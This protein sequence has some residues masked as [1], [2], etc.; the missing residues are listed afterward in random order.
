MIDDTNP[1]NTN[2]YVITLE[3]KTYNGTTLATEIKNKI[4]TTTSL[5]SGVNFTYSVQTNILSGSIDGFIAVFFN[6]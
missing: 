4:M 1:L 3:E 6:W 5:S 2:Y